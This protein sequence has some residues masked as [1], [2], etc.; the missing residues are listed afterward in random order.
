[1]GNSTFTGR[2]LLLIGVIGAIG[3]FQIATIR[4]GHGWGDDFA[5]YIQQA[6]KLAGDLPTGDSGYIYNP[7]YPELGPPAYPPL[8]PLLLV[9][10]YRHFGLSL[11]VMKVEIVLCFL[12]ALIILSIMFAAHLPFSELIV[13]IAVLGFSPFFWDAKDR[14]GS[15]LPF[16]ALCSLA[17]Y[18]MTLLQRRARD[19]WWLS[20]F[21]G[22]VI[23]ACY[24][25]RTIG[26]VLLPCLVL[27]ELVT[28]RRISRASLISCAVALALI[29]MNSSLFQVAGNYAGDIH[30]SWQAIA[31][32]LRGYF[33]EIHSSLWPFYGPEGAQVFTLVLFV[34]GIAGYISRVRSGISVLEVFAATYT[35]AIL[36]WTI[37]FDSRFLIP[38]IP[39][40]LYYIISCL[41]Q[42]AA[43]HFGSNQRVVPVLLLT[44]FIA[45]YAS[46]YT[47]KDFGPIRQGIGDPRFVEACTF[48]KE[49]TPAHAVVVFAK[50]RLLAL[51]TDRRA[52]AYHEPPVDSELWSY[53][54]SISAE[55]ILVS[56]ELPNDI[57]YF[58]GFIDREGPKVSLM[59]D[60]GRFELY[61]IRQ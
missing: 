42:I 45:S 25:A 24:T 3:I 27:Y 31:R 44:L 47:R 30:L 28:R 10:I 12:L 5:M 6:K 39:L 37:D 35:A 19:V 16:F 59:F 56:N 49:E 60:N 20:A 4:Q 53:F 58:H 41:R 22:F 61:R 9:P 17:L 38:V 57:A 55:Y 18:L 23:Y 14:I 15:D 11:G 36:L 34:L 51:V 43:R 48:I 13:L 7:H 50:P 21:L 8:Y 46:A 32:N 2:S 52:V 1:M 26:I 33:W 29:G 54:S 40:W